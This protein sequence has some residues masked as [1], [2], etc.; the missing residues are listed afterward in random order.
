MGFT[1]A[2]IIKIT[3]LWSAVLLAFPFHLS[4]LTISVFPPPS[5]HATISHCVY[6]LHSMHPQSSHKALKSE[7]MNANSSAGCVKNTC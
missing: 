2:I 1:G 4:Y 6:I 3:T 5:L 7:Y